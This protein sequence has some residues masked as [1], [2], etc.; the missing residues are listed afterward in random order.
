MTVLDKQ[1]EY[2]R[3]STFQMIFSPRLFQDVKIQN[4]K[5]KAEK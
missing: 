5:P 1:A 4:L 3:A 2:L